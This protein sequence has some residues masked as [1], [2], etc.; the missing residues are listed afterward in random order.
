VYAPGLMMIPSTLPRAAWMRSTIAPS[1]FDLLGTREPHVYGHTTLSDVE[2]N[3][4][5]IAASHGAVLESSWSSING[6][7]TLSKA[8]RIATEVCVYAPGLMMIPSTLP[9][10]S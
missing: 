9:R 8:S 1:W 3:S 10:A 2:S 5:E 6:T 4:R 7:S